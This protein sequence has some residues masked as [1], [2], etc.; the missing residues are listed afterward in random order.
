MLEMMA[1]LLPRSN[2][3]NRNYGCMNLIMSKAFISGESASVKHN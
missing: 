1:L 2:P 3:I